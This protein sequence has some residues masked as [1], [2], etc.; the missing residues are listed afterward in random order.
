MEDTDASS[1]FESSNKIKRT[2][3][4]AKKPV[5]APVKKKPDFDEDE[6][7]VDDDFEIDDEELM[8]EVEITK[9]TTTRNG[10]KK[11]NTMNKATEVAPPVDKPK[12]PVK[13]KA[14]VK[15]E[16]SSEDDEFLDPKSAPKPD[17]SRRTPKKPKASEPATIKAQTKPAVKAAPKTTAQTTPKA[18]KKTESKIEEEDA[19]RK[20]I[21]ESVE[22]VELPDT[23]P[24]VGDGKYTLH[25]RLCLP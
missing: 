23:A 7:I 16:E 25:P 9:P 3:M 12:T 1:Y 22:T 13:R 2:A 8:Q 15:D 11:E 20:A 14:L 6:F 21:L 5:P 24:A 4:P 19:E 10:V 18:T 17:I